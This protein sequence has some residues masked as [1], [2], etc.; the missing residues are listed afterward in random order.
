[1]KAPIRLAIAAGGTSGHIHPALAVAVAL[2]RRFPDAEVLFI[3]TARGLESRVVPRASF[4]FHPIRA[5]GFPRKI[6]LAA[7]KALA[8][9]FAGRREAI[10]LLEDFRPDVV[11]GT[12]GYVCGPVVSAANRLGIPVVLHEQNAYPGRANRL[13][14][15]RAR[16]V[17]TSFPDGEKTFP[18]RVPVVRTG[19]PVRPEFFAVDRDEA[20]LALG[21]PEDA[22]FVLA[23]GGSLGARTINRAVLAML[24]EGTAP[25][26][27]RILL[28][29]GD[30]LFAEVS[31]ETGFLEERPDELELVSYLEEP[32]LQMAAADLIV[33]RAGAGACSEI[34]AL[35]K[36]SV[37][38]PY[39]YAANDHQTFN[40]RFLSDVGAAVICPD[41][42][43]DGAELRRLLEGVLLDRGRCLRMAAAAKSLARE[44]SADRIV[45]CLL[46]AAGVGSAT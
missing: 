38:V 12:G 45:A 4:L 32:H 27:A 30:A 23:L 39:P 35:G 6:S 11:L 15:R 24:R 1:M 46:E 22:R 41:G 44:D 8:D 40:A 36:P 14:S 31:A 9:L 42:R 37:L 2:R 28:A 16:F 19:Y 7:L 20:R 33:C 21:I 29:T 34:A 25:G 5:S 18:K 10:R 43:L 26:G 17:C 3:G 13:L